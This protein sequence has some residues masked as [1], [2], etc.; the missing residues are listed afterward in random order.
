M[1]FLYIRD[2]I[3]FFNLPDKC[4]CFSSSQKEKLTLQKQ[5][6]RLYSGLCREEVLSNHFIL[7]VTGT[8][9]KVLHPF[10]AIH[11]TLNYSVF[12]N[13]MLQKCIYLPPW[14]MGR[15]ETEIAHFQIRRPQ[16]STI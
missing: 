1:E 11:F 2:I 9:D 13:S 5:A 10:K 16:C 7:L 6:L 3:L 15:E 14:K 8:L 12:C 4:S